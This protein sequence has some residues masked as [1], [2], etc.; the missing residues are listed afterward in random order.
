VHT[1]KISKYK[2]LYKF[3]VADLRTIARLDSIGAVSAPAARPRRTLG[4]WFTGMAVGVT[5][6]ILAAVVTWVWLPQW[7]PYWVIA[8]SPWLD[9]IVRAEAFIHPTQSYP[10]WEFQVQVHTKFGTAALPALCRYAQSRSDALR[11]TA[12]HGIEALLQ[13]YSPDPWADFPT[14]SHASLPISLDPQ[15]LSILR[16][17]ATT[18]VNATIRTVAFG[19]VIRWSKSDENTLKIHALADPNAELRAQAAEAMAIHPLDAQIPALIRATT[20]TSWNVRLAALDTL[21]NRGGTT[22]D[23][24]LFRALDDPSRGVS[25]KA[26][27]LLLRSTT[28]SSEHRHIVLTRMLTALHD[29]GIRGNACGALDVLRNLHAADAQAAL[30]ELLTSPDRQAR[31]FAAHVL[32]QSSIAASP[33][34]IAVSIE[35]LASDEFPW[36]KSPGYTPVRNASSSLQWLTA[37]VQADD[38]LIAAI[39]LARDLQQ[40]FCCALILALH[41]RQDLVS[42]IAPLLIPHLQDNHIQRDAAW[43]MRGLYVLGRDVEPWL[44]RALPHADKQGKQLITLLLKNL[45]HPPV[46][47]AAARRDSP[48][49]RLFE[50]AQDPSFLDTYESYLWLN[51]EDR[52]STR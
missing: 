14:S 13:P 5:L 27:F 52:W 40:R 34:L 48:V 8:H 1:F 35:A 41:R 16:N 32:R 26:A 39:P 38:A 21:G 7:R 43:A 17:C 29:D 47:D 36:S 44:E 45:R 23:Q 42:V 9:P 30:A 20:D 4:L 6:I 11:L 28:L 22:G 46:D 31:Q 18:D 3:S 25:T 51:D 19:M 24:T 33:A 49:W 37:I 10:S 50:H 15:T 2:Y 12:L